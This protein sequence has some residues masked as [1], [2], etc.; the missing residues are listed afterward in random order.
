MSRRPNILFIMADQ[1]RYD[2]NGY[3]G[4]PMVRTPNLDKLAASGARFSSA[5]TPCPVCSPTRQ[6]LLCGLWPETHGGTWN[7]GGCI[8][9]KGFDAP[10]VTALMAESGYRQ[11][12]VGKWG[13]APA[14]PQDCG[15]VDAIGQGGYA[16]YRASQNVGEPTMDAYAWFGG[17][18]PA[19]PEQTLTHWRAR[20]AIG[21]MEQY[22]QSDQPWHLRLDFSEPHLP[23]VPSQHFLDMYNADDIEQWGNFPDSFNGKPYI[24]R[25]QLASW[26]LTEM[27]WSDWQRYLR[28]Y[29]AML[30][31]VDDAV[32]TV[33]Q[34]LEASG[35]AEN[36]IVI[37][38]TDHGDA[39]GSHG[40]I[41]KH[42]TQYQEL[43]HVPLLI[44]WPGVTKP[45]SVCDQFVM[46]ALDLS[47]SLCDWS[48]VPEPELMHGR[49]L[50]PL[51]SGE[52]PEDWRKY[53]YGTYNGQQFGLF[54]QRMVCN[55]EWKY[56]WNLTDVDELYHLPS[57][58][59][60]MQNLVADSAHAEVLKGLRLELLRHLRERKEPTVDSPWAADQL[61]LGWKLT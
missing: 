29:F 58:P 6:S 13:V 49:S 30:T 56:V 60:E 59:W 27:Q 18:D 2:C 55:H 32:G 45:G 4:H 50:R 41:D 20:Q 23:C 24:H 7:P 1:H 26:G 25:Q 16:A 36:T 38:S 14:T 54:T 3:T 42:Y 51:L 15:F 11:G 17:E 61:Q 37:Y 52:T 34:S 31:Q 28:R 48:G 44:R 46:H 43:V 21:L 35:E 33:L 19:A 12:H 39:A 8:P 40:M 57:D 10:T 53:A 5:Y 22:V 47:A 9:P